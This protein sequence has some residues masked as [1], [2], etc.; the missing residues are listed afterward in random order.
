MRTKTA[1]FA[2][3]CLVVLLTFS[4]CGQKTAPPAETESSGTA[5]VAESGPASAP[6]AAPEASL[7]GVKLVE[8]IAPKNFRDVEFETPYD[9]LS[10]AGALITVVS[11]KK[12]ECVGADGLK[13]QAVA[14]PKD[15]KVADYEGVLFIGGPGM[16]DYISDASFI[17]LAKAFASADK[18]MAAICVAPAILA[19]AGLLDGKTATAFP[20]V[21]PTLKAKGAHVVTDDVAV[22]GKIITANGPPAAA[23]FAQALLTA[24]SAKPGKAPAKP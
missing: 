10:K 12:G 2:L 7:R 13:V 23:H 16:M 8:V 5:P 6:A 3:L 24:L 14:T 9:V 15:I 20:D 4:A 21:L 18:L 22:A 1:L 11:T 17:A 19:N